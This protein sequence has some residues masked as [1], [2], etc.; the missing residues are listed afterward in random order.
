MAGDSD[1]K[2][3]ASRLQRRG[4]LAHPS[5][6][7]NFN[8]TQLADINLWNEDSDF[9]FYNSEKVISFWLSLKK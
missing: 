3:P 5:G 2:G 6:V 1:G 9:N 4:R 8:K 7:P